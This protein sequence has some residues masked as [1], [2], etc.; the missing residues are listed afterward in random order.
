VVAGPA[1]QWWGQHGG[2]GDDE[3]VPAAAACEGN[4]ILPR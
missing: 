1:W 3:G 4:K 2:G